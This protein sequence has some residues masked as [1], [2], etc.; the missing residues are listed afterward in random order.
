MKVLKFVLAIVFAFMICGVLFWSGLEAYL[1]AANGFSIVVGVGG[2]AA[3]MLLVV[4]SIVKI[5]A[6]VLE[7]EVRWA[8][9]I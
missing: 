1:R 9:K 6:I 3:A 7:L 8:Y 2:M 5:R 4:I